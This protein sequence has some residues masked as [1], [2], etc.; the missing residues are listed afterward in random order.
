[1]DDTPTGIGDMSLL[2]W[3]KMHPRGSVECFYENEYPI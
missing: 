3:P 1:M 2:R